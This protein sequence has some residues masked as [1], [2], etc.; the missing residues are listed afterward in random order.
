MSVPKSVAEYVNHLTT[1]DYAAYIY[2]YTNIED[3]KWYVGYHLGRP[4]DGYLESSTNKEFRSLME[5]SKPIFKYEILYCGSH[6]EMKNLEHRILSDQNA[7]TNAM[8]YNLSNGSPNNKEIRVG[9]CEEFVQRYQ[10][11]DFDIGKQPINDYKGL[12]RLQ[13]RNEELDS[14]NVRRI[15][16]L[17]DEQGGNTDKCNEILIY[18]GVLIDGNHTIEGAIKSKKATIVPISEPSEEEVAHYNFTSLELDFISKLCN[19]EEE[20]IRKSNQKED[21]VKMLKKMKNQNPKLELDSGHI[22]DILKTAGVRIKKERDA[23]IR[24]ATKELSREYGRDAGKVWV[25][26]TLK[27]NKS[28]IEKKVFDTRDNQTVA[29]YN[30]SA[31][32]RKIDEDFMQNLIDSPDKPNIVMVVYHADE[33]YKKKWD[34]DVR[35]SLLTKYNALLSMMKPIIRNGI[36]VPRTVRFEE[37]P[38]WK[39]EI[40]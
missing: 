15:S 6:A 40:L 9:L 17:I 32:S 2:K 26:Y 33:N 7:M 28:S 10:A 30:S 13:A 16:Q 20:I 18:D 31:I 12:P 5:G 8:S 24:Q 14:F 21:F 1:D 22:I 29:F 23:I 37:M 27:N 4:L 38:C 36:E 11:G 35:N 25:N 34:Q 3:G 39:N 19:K